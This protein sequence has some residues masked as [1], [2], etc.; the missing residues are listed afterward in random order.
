[1]DYIIVDTPPMALLADTEE[2]AHMADASVLVVK[3]D[4]AF[5][6]D[7]NDSIDALNRTEAKVIGCIFNDVTA[8]FVER[9]GHYGYGSYYGY[10][11]YYGKQS[12]E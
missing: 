2:I 10:G 1:M 5:A 4:S 12:K 8:G 11:G 3:Q 9:V 7:I 6:R